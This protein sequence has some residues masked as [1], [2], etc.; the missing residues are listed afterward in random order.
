MNNNKHTN[1]SRVEKFHKVV[2]QVANEIKQ[3]LDNKDL[4]LGPLARFLWE[5]YQRYE[6]QLELDE[7]IQQSGKKNDQSKDMEGGDEK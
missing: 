4:D 5:F 3:R 7:T 6:K 2:G 1:I